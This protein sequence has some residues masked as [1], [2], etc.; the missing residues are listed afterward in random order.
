M[1]LCVTGHLHLGAVDKD[2][3][4]PNAHGPQ[5]MATS[6]RARIIF[7][8][9]RGGHQIASPEGRLA[10][11]RQGDPEMPGWGGTQPLGVCDSD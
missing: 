7:F 5:E 11:A 2:Q 3:G 8:R 6:M 10:K 9:P 1:F 4:R